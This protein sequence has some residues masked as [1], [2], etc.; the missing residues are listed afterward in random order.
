MRTR[1]GYPEPLCTCKDG[2]PDPL[3]ATHG[4]FVD[5]WSGE[6]RIAIDE[7]PAAELERRERARRRRLKPFR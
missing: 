4:V 5:R 1:S 3:C 6:F 7:T 2:K